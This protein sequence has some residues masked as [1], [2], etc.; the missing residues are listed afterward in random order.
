M[1][2][3][4]RNSLIRQSVTK[5]TAGLVGVFA[6]GMAAILPVSA[7]V[8]T[9][10]ETPANQL[11]PSA[12]MVAPTAPIAPTAP[13]APVAPGTPAPISPNAQTPAPAR[14]NPSVAVTTGNIV[15]VASASDSF[16]T[17]VAALTEAELTEVLQGEGPFTVFAPTDAAFASLPAGSVEKLL[18]PENRAML[19][20]ILKYHVVAG[21]YPSADL[22]SGEVPTVEGRAVT[23]T[24][25]DGKVMVNNANVIQPDIAATNG[26][27]HAI[28]QVIVPPGM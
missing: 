17:L 25:G 27:I 12:E 24:V 19:V 21:A 3:L 18:K 15:D 13:T 28:D 26:V 14:P 20:Q 10:V 8:R 16:Q 5:R 1:N 2:S 6:V 7:Q 22:S 11:K 4:N 9:E 23:I